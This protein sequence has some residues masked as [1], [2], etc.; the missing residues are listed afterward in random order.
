MRRKPRL[1][2]WKTTASGA[3]LLW[4]TAATVLPAQTFTTVYSFD[5]TD[6][7]NSHA[8][9][10]QGTNGELYGT[11]FSG[12]ANS[13]GTVFKITLRGVLTTLYNLCEKTD[14]PDGFFPKAALALDTGGNLYGTSL[15][16]DAG[17]YGTVFRITPSGMLTTLFSMNGTDGA[18]PAGLVLGR[19]GNFYGTTEAGG[20][21]VEA[22][23]IRSLRVEL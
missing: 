19:D 11:T 2:D 10:V 16:G 1:I 13:A 22:I 15:G 17:G 7:S 5:G 12:G 21:T 6:G 9:L 23:S 3:L 20:S 4:A 14:C 18:N 8:G